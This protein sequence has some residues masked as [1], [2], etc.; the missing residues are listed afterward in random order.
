MERESSFGFEALAGRIVAGWVGIEMAI[1]DEDADGAPQ[2]H[3]PL[4]PVLQLS[5]LQVDF[6]DGPSWTLA[7]DFVVDDV[8]GLHVR[9]EE[10]I[11]SSR[12]TRAEGTYRARRL[13]ELPVGEVHGVEVVVG[14]AGE[15]AEVRV[16]IGGRDLL[17][18]A[19]EIEE[20]WTERLRYVR[21]DLSVL[22]FTDPA[23]ADGID[24]YPP[25]GAGVRYGPS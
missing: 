1:R 21:G 23:A 24:W 14:E 17:L 25:R 7:P 9:A 2:F 15:I 16:R 19:G 20:T 18:M 4:V 13:D 5:L 8:W 10:P 3:D 6:V 11:E 22:V 12:L